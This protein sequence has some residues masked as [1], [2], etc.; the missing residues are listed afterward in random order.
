MKWV[1]RG[2][3][4]VLDVC[5]QLLLQERVAENMARIKD[6]QEGR[7]THAAAEPGANDMRY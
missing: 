2:A 7:G 5:L 3:G 6:L 1:S 4:Y